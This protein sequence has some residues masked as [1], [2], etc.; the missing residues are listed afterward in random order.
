MFTL[1]VSSVVREH[2]DIWMI[3]KICDLVP[4]LYRDVTHGEV[5]ML[6]DCVCKMK[7]LNLNRWH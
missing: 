1:T 3:H 5:A 4:Y 6:T 7:R 2:I